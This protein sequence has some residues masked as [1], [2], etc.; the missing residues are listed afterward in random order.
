MPDTKLGDLTMSSQLP[1]KNLPDLITQWVTRFESHKKKIAAEEKII[2]MKLGPKT[3]YYIQHAPEVTLSA[4]DPRRLTL[5]RYKLFNHLIEQLK[6]NDSTNDI[7]QLLTQTK[8][9]IETEVPA[10]KS[11]HSSLMKINPLIS[12]FQIELSQFIQA[13]KKSEPSSE[14]KR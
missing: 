5:Y 10:K 1:P 8:A 9:I 3:T 7:H 4:K 12:E 6:A 2:E 13:Q 11:N 14:I